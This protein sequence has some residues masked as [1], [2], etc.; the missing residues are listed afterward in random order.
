VLGLA[1]LPQVRHAA[2]GAPAWCRDPMARALPA[3]AQALDG[4]GQVCL[5]ADHFRSHPLI[6]DYLN[7]TFYGGR[8]RIRTNMRT[9][10]SGLPTAHTGLAWHNVVGK[11]EP[12]KEG[13]PAVNVGELA[14]C[15]QLLRTWLR[16]GLLDAAPRRSFG[17][18]SPIPE[19]PSALRDRL[20]ASTFPLKQLKKLYIGPPSMFCGRQ[21][22]FLIVLPGPAQ[23]GPPG[24]NAALSQDEALFHDAV[25][26]AR[27][28]LHVVGDH[29]ACRMAGGYAAALADHIGA[30]PQAPEATPVDETDARFEAAF[31]RLEEASA[32]LLTPLCKLLDAAGYAYQ[33]NIEEHGQQFAVRLLSP[34]GGRYVLDFERPLE[35][36][37][38]AD[39]LELDLMRDAEVGKLGYEVVR[40]AADDLLE[41]ADLIVERLARLA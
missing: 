24:H 18:V 7:R 1:D 22:D 14:G 6:A 40:I 30:P 25:A 3:L 38:A 37:A 33:C 35:D 26:A 36:I 41:K 20:K 34:H 27:I 11:V 16:E 2:A 29:Q 15:E 9:L 31:G 13:E 21:V 4:T 32:D 19:Q 39:E 28:G 5:L 17:I 12:P 23:S 10:C 8:M